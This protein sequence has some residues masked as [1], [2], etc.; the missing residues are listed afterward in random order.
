MMD[1][2]LAPTE[3]AERLGVPAARVRGWCRRGAIAA[4]KD[5]R[6]RWRVPGAE[7]G[8]MVAIHGAVPQPFPQG[9]TRNDLLV[10][11]ALA[12]ASRGFLSA[13]SVGV[14]VNL[15]PTTASRVLKALKARGLLR[16]VSEPRLWRGRSVER[17]VWYANLLVEDF[18]GLLPVLHRVEL[19][20]Q[21]ANPGRRL[22]EHVWH[23][24]WN[25]EP[26]DIDVVRDAVYLAHRAMTLT[27]PEGIAWAVTTLP[28]VA[29]ERALEMRG[30]PESNR[31]WLRAAQALQNGAG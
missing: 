22:P 4:E 25:A 30:V 11:A 27:D 28:P 1:G 6:G 23:L 26:R 8:R 21:A 24:V 7:L 18:E 13:G 17:S 16:R 20:Q 15:S 19:P 3:V 14:R 9:F 5:E 29:F 10:L 2:T 12:R 31:A